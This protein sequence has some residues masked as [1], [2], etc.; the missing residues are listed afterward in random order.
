M[1]PVVIIYG[2]FLLRLQMVQLFKVIQEILRFSDRHEP[3]NCFVPGYGCGE[4]LI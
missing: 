2:N 1:N 3:E 4:H